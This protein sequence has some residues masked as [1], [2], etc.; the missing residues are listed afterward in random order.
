MRRTAQRVDEQM[1]DYMRAHAIPGRGRPASACWSASSESPSCAGAGALCA[2]AGR[3][4]ARAMDGA[5]CR[6]LARHTPD[7]SGARPDRRRP[8][9]GRAARRRGRHH[10][11]ARRGRR[12]SST[13]RAPTTSPISSSRKSPGRAG[14]NC[15]TARSTQRLIR[16]RRRHQRPCHRRASASRATATASAAAPTARRHAFDLTA[17]A[18]SAVVVAGALGIGLRAATSSSTF[19]HRAGV[20]DRGADE[21]GR[22]T[23]CGRALF[24]CLLSVLAYNFFFL[25]P[26]YTFTIADPENVV[27]LFF[28]L[29]SRSSPAT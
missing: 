22:P 23:A 15:S 12:R 2:A 25:P 10:P 14:A 18:G 4:A 17:Y 26:L 1:V 8:A 16:Q 7:R 5:P 13:T 27:A 19:Q 9:A 6:D 20:P 3:P 21:R 28:F 29:S 24:A 11:G